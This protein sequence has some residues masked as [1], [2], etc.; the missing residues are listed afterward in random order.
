[1]LA[2]FLQECSCFVLDRVILQLQLSV[3]QCTLQTMFI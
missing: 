2:T 3:P 1:M